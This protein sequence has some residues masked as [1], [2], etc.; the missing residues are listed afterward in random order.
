ML[1]KNS[2]HRP[3]AQFQPVSKLNFTDEKASKSEVERQEVKAGGDAKDDLSTNI[4]TGAIQE[5]QR[6]I[7]AECKG[8][9][10]LNKMVGESFPKAAHLLLSIPGRIL[11]TGLGKSGHIARKIASTMTSTGSPAFFLNPGD[12]N[13]GDLGAINRGDGIII[14]SRSG[15]VPEL[16]QAVAKCHRLAVPIIAIT[17]KPSSKLATAANATVML[18]VILF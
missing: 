18:F 12:L 6:V 5:A 4:V 2:F 1:T 14:L 8:L 3:N 13:H 17:A 7:M 9:E 15:D 16:T 10:H 11:V